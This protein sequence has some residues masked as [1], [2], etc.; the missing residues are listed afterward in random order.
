M[1]KY[2]FLLVF[3]SSRFAF[4]ADPAPPTTPAPAADST[5]K[6]EDDNKLSDSDKEA[7]SS[8]EIQ[9]MREVLK[10]VL[11]MLEQ[12]RN[13]KDVVRLNCVNEKLTQVKGFIRIAEQSDVAL[14]EDVAKKEPASANH[15]FTKI[16]VAAQ[17]VAQLRAEAEACGGVE[18]YTT[19]VGGAE[20][21]TTE[22]SDLPANTI[23]AGAPPPAVS[24]TPPPP[25]TNSTQQ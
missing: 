7:R 10:I 5:L 22:P 25:A 23:A 9:K 24:V 13:S 18:N 2:A 19:G 3:A 12:A 15:E 14:Q 20:V 21:V 17:R 16:E 11:G 8:A 4:A 6:F 1:K